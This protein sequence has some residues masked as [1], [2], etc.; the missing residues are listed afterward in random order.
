MPA[1]CGCI[2]LNQLSRLIFSHKAIHVMVFYNLFH[3][4]HATIIYL[5]FVCIEYA[6][7]D[8]FLGEMLVFQA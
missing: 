1:H 8:V 5:G 6:V 7:V 2:C 3:V 4:L